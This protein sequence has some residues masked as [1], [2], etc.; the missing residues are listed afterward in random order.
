MSPDCCDVSP[1]SRSN[2]P[3][4]SQ[5]CEVNNL[6]GE[7]ATHLQLEDP[8]SA[9]LTS[10]SCSRSRDEEHPSVRVFACVVFPVLEL[11]P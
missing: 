8:C 10:L 1:S 9:V 6:F 4:V 5:S 7:A 11:G 2:N 3:Y